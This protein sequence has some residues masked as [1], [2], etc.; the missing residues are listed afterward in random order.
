MCCT[1]RTLRPP[2]PALG[3]ATFLAFF[4]GGA[5]SDCVFAERDRGRLFDGGALAVARGLIK[6]GDEIGLQNKGL[7]DAAPGGVAVASMRAMTSAAS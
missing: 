2:L 5:F 4:W 7:E 1:Q 6:V 3:S